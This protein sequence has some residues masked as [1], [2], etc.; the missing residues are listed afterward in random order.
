[1]LG[2]DCWLFVE[3]SGC[4]KVGQLLGQLA[5]DP[6][7]GAAPWID[8]QASYPSGLGCME[9]SLNGE[10]SACVGIQLLAYVLFFFIDLAENK[11]DMPRVRNRDNN[12]E[13]GVPRWVFPNSVRWFRT[14]PPDLEE[15]DY[16]VCEGA[17]LVG[18]CIRS[19]PEKWTEL[20]EVW[21]TS[22][23][24][25]TDPDWMLPQAFVDEQEGLV[26]NIFSFLLEY[27]N[28]DTYVMFPLGAKITVTD[29]DEEFMVRHGVYRVRGCL[30]TMDVKKRFEFWNSYGVDCESY[31][32]GK[33]DPP[34]ELSDPALRSLR[35]SRRVRG[36]REEF[37]L[38]FHPVY[39]DPDRWEPFVYGPQKHTDHELV[40]HWGRPMVNMK[41]AFPDDI[42]IWKNTGYGQ[43]GQE[44]YLMLAFREKKEWLEAMQAKH[45]ARLCGNGAIQPRKKKKRKHAWNEEQRR[46]QMRKVF[47]RHLMYG[48]GQPSLVLEETPPYA[49]DQGWDDT[50]DDESDDEVGSDEDV[51]AILNDDES[52]SDLS[53]DEEG[54]AEEAAEDISIISISSD[55][56]SIISI[57]SDGSDDTSIVRM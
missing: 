4:D 6:T 55:D 5:I 11:V 43:R 51:P 52:A 13:S 35:A 39:F 40:P 19:Q 18:Y 1:M 15:R 8:W 20:K 22:A 25:T 50:D 36:P 49:F 3:A 21:R 57:S 47:L 48:E 28:P 32:I 14:Q 46:E 29:R 42:D 2:F 34:S 24:W 45:T 17:P 33:A 30:T 9:R 31:G 54:A 56:V 10:T 16:G 12:R 38:L 41:G 53:V 26:A 44:S 27:R 7:K 23:E 37:G